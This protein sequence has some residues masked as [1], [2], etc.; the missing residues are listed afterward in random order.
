MSNTPIMDRNPADR[1]R[2]C[3]YLNSNTRW[4]PCKQGVAGPEE[5]GCRYEPIDG[6]WSD[7]EV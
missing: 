7:G 4:H 3:K 6:Y 5:P 1:C 2:H